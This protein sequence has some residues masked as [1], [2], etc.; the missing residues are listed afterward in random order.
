MLQNIIT[1]IQNALL[2]AVDFAVIGGVFLFSLFAF[3]ITSLGFVL[4]TLM[5]R[6]KE[7]EVIDVK[8][9]RVWFSEK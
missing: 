4:A 5:A 2:A 9:D 6:G 8:A 1:F 7:D 3:C